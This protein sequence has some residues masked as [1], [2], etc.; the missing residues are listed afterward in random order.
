ME[1]TSEPSSLHP[2]AQRG[3]GDGAGEK[4]VGLLLCQSIPST[5]GVKDGVR[6]K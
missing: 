2:C 6:G 1:Y 5:L 4:L 3:L